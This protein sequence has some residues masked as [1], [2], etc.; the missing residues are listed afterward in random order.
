MVIVWLLYGY[1]MVIVWLLYGYCMVKAGGREEEDERKGRSRG[2]AG[3]KKSAVIRCDRTF[4]LIIF[5]RS[6]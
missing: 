6:D 3:V 5:L 2:E 4:C 1:C